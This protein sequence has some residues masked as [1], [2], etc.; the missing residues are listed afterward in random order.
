MPKWVIE[1]KTHE[2]HR[3]AKVDNQGKLEYVAFRLPNKTGL[4]QP[5][6][7]KPFGSN[8]PNSDFETWA[9]GEDK[10][11][12]ILQIDEDYMPSFAD[13]AVVIQS[14]D[15]NVAALATAN[16]KITDLKGQ[17]EELEKE[18]FEMRKKG[19]AYADTQLQSTNSSEVQVQVKEVIKEVIVEKQ[20]E[21]IK[22]VVKEVQVPTKAHSLDLSSKP[23]LGYWDIRGLGAPIRY[24]LHYCKIPFEDK[25]YKCGPKP[26]YDKSAWLEEKEK[27]REEGME[28]PNLPYLVDSDIKLTETVAIMKYICAKWKPE[29]LHTDPVVYAKAEMIQDRVMALKQ[30]STV[31][32][33]QG[34]SNQEIM[35]DLWEP[36]QEMV[37]L[38]M[39]RKWLC[40]ENLTWLDFY[41]FE[42]AM[43]LDML[44]G[45]VVCQHYEVLGNYVKSFKE[46]EDF[47]NVWSD[48]NKCMKWPWNGDMASIGGRD[49]QQ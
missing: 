33:Y 44:S 42:L 6:L 29:L 4:F 49:S 25:H 15:P 37:E 22:E 35:D 48:D 20:V 26:D 31:P 7:Y 2:V 41:F 13:A 39:N 18:N 9:K 14:N 30:K 11:A 45:E 19:G 40:G 46:L 21:V 23:V 10:P 8:K 12:N 24:L 28:L 17:V 1:P 43:F 47:K 5:E 27:L 16:K 3:F 34:K 36:I 32:C 38:L